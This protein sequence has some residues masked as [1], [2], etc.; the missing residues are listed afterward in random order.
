MIDASPDPHPAV[1]TEAA[2]MMA[3]ATVFDPELA[4]SIVDLGLIY[5]VAVEDDR[6]RVTLTLTAPGCPIH[7]VI[8]DWART[9]VARIPGVGHVDLDVTF[10]P[11]WTPERIR[12]ARRR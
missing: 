8:T 11:P 9:V 6:V 3:L 1:P 5:G 4:M 7:E 10:D 2:V 12:P